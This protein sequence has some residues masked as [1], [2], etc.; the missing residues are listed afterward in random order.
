M[1]RA[2]ARYRP[3]R[4][5]F[6]F[7]A[8]ALAGFGGS[9]W[10]ADKIGGIWPVAAWVFGVTAA[11]ILVGAL[12]PTIEIHET[13]LAVG[14]RI[15]F[16]NEI[17]RLD[18]TGWHAPLAVRLT[19][20]D[21]QSLL[22]IHPGDTGSSASLLR[23]LLRYSRMALLDGLPYNHFWGETAD[24]TRS[25]TQDRLLLPEDELE[26]ELLFQRLRTVGSLDHNADD[27]SAD[28]GGADES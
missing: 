7:G 15:V 12:R 19:L 22:L 14:R 1:R 26:V 16:W 21:G 25:G 27:D 23:H 2:V 28:Q 8:L 5:Y 13:H 10:A 3:S 17:A 18:R 9:L 11:A 20:T 6:A 24:A 4:S